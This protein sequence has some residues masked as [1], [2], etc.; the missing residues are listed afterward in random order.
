MEKPTKLKLFIASSKE[1][2]EEREAFDTLFAHLSYILE[3]KGISFSAVKWEFM[4]QGL[5]KER[6]QN[7]YNEELKK[8]QF[9]IVLFGEHLGDYTVEELNIAYNELCSPSPHSLNTV[10]VYFKNGLQESKALLD[11]KNGFNAKYNDQFYCSYQNCTDLHNSVLFEILN[12]IVDHKILE[13]K[14][15]DSAKKEVEEQFIDEQKKRFLAAYESNGRDLQKTCSE[16]DLSPEQIK[17]WRNTDKVFD[18]QLRYIKRKHYENWFKKNRLYFILAFLLVLLY[19]IGKPIA[20]HMKEVREEEEAILAIEQMKRKILEPYYV[21][22][23]DFEATVMKIEQTTNKEVEMENLVEILSSIKEFE[24]EHFEPSD[25]QYE[26]YQKRV[27]GLWKDVYSYYS[28]IYS[29]PQAS[30]SEQQDAKR[31][32]ELLEDLKDSIN[33]VRNN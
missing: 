26:K 32:M 9:C 18:N 33:D 12:Y 3:P 16:L 17:L 1:L 24:D 20:R 13:E 30:E 22:I 29:N 8:C 14:E 2:I 19:F 7:L 21:S 11:F 5:S 28:N 27:V 10:L 31:S 6:K 23:Y 15:I 4:P 25:R